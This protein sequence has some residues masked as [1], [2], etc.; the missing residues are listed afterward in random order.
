MDRKETA[1]FGHSADA[2]RSVPS[3][4]TRADTSWNW[5][6]PEPKAPGWPGGVLARYLTVGEAVVDVIDK[7][8]GHSSVWRYEMECGGCTEKISDRSEYGIRRRAQSHAERCRA[9][10]KPEGV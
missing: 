2:Y 8:E 1:A 7:G 9:L 6:A 3:E 5:P 10:P 4:G